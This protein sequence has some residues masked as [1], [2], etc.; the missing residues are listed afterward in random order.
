LHA[1]DPEHE[2]EEVVEMREFSLDLAASDP[3]ELFPSEEIARLG[4]LFEGRSLA[5]WIAV[6]AFH[7]STHL[8][9]DK[10]LLSN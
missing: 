8:L 4:N 6:T 3:L 5:A 9:F 2:L 7:G 10:E 1:F